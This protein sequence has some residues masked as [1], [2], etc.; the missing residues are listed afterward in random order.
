MK[1][2]K[3]T[4]DKKTAKA[5]KPAAKTADAKPEAE[6]PTAPPAAEVFRTERTPEPRFTVHEGHARLRPGYTIDLFGRPHMVVMVN[7]SRALCVPL[8]RRTQTFKAMK[9]GEEVEMTLSKSEEGVA[10][11]PNSECTIIK[12]GG[13]VELDAFLNPKVEEAAVKAPKAPKA[14][15]Q[16]RGESKCGFIDAL[17]TKGGLTFTQICKKAH[18]KFGGSEL[19]TMSTVRARPSHMRAKGLKPKWVE[20]KKGG[21]K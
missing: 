10:I 14:P 21:G 1:H 6:A 15:K 9:N 12:K 2:P 4:L 5:K 7:Y 20:E 16:P 3:K 13:A 11:S 19:S 17:F 18:E 8:S